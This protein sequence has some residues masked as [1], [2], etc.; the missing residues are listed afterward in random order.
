MRIASLALRIGAILVVGGGLL[1]LSG[2]GN[3]STSGGSG[4]TT[5]ERT[6]PSDE[7]GNIPS[8]AETLTLQYHYINQ[9]NYRAA[10]DM[11]TADSRR[12]IS[13][14]QYAGWFTDQGKY[15]WRAP[16][17]RGPGSGFVMPAAQEMSRQCPGTAGA[18]RR[19]FLPRSVLV[20]ADQANGLP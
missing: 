12:L 14:E 8:P 13:Y 17:E 1:V 16:V 19:G 18:K 7:E 20:K 2:C 10:Y 6:I 15:T 5:V 9:G 11:F 4:S 3:E